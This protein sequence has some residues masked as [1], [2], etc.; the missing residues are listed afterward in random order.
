MLSF[1]DL[2]EMSAKWD[3]FRSAPAWKT[4]SADARFAFDPIVS[5]I[6][7]LL[8]SPLDCSQM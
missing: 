8:L 4:L 5:N 7:N 3:V 6:S 1:A 2:T